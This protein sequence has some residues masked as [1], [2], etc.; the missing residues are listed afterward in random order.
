MLGRET[1]AQQWQR[2]GRRRLALPFN[3][4]AGPG[5]RAGFIRPVK[6]ILLT[7]RAGIV[8]AEK[9]ALSAIAP[10]HQRRKGGWPQFVRLSVLRQQPL[11]EAAHHEEQR[12]QCVNAVRAEPGPGAERRRVAKFGFVKNRLGKSPARTT[13]ALAY[14]C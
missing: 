6:H 12:I 11:G 8:V 4:E 10:T 13:G 7:A 14:G 2:T 5:D 3:R 9:Y 1:I